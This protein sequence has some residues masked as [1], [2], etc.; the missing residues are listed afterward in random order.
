VWGNATNDSYALQVGIGA[1]VET[2]LGPALLGV[3]FGG[4]GTRQV[5]IGFGGIFP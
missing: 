5:H 2:L 3:T 1:L 4:H